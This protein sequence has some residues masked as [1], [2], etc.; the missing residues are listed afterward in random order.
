MSDADYE[1]WEIDAHTLA[2]HEILGRYLDGWY[3]TLSSYGDKLIYFDGFAGRGR[4]NDDS[5]GSPIIALRRLLDHTYFPRLA[6]RE[7]VF[8]FV[9][10][11]KANFDS[12]QRE[13]DFLRE[14]IG[15]WPK[16]VSVTCV[17]G[18]FD[19][20]AQSIVDFL[21][22]EKARMAPVLAFIDPFGYSGIP[23]ALMAE[24]VASPASEVFVNFMVGHVQRFIARDGQESAMSSLFG[25]DRETILEGLDASGQPR[26]EYLRDVY[27]SEMER[28]LGFRYV[29]G[30]EMKNITGNVG[31]YLFHGTNHPKGVELMK[32]AMWKADPTGGFSFSSRQAIDPQGT[33]D[34]EVDVSPCEDAIMRA[35]SGRKNVPGPEIKDWCV[36]GT[37]YLP[38]HVTAALK[39]LEA[40]RMITVHRPPNGQFGPRS[41]VDFP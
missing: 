9:E 2:K 35:F 33:L 26:V 21:K 39:S 20:T 19:Q 3:P 22:A 17:Q 16:N 34:F 14:E 24:F 1:K 6:A 30:F 29:R 32:D 4:Y 11:N 36:T 15:G 10:K 28:Q 8:Y 18:R 37:D 38:R 25:I 27:K 5:V 7:F 12:L 13:V 31:Y 23:M 41:R 40:R